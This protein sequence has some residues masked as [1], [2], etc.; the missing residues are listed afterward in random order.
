M[1]KD[2]LVIISPWLI[3]ICINP[4]MSCRVLRERRTIV[5]KDSAKSKEAQHKVVRDD[6][7]DSH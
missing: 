6:S 3:E 2:T 1:D 5:S 4:S 7:A